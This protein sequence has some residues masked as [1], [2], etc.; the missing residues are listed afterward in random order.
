[1]RFVRIVAKPVKFH[2]SR[3][4]EDQF[5][6]KSAFQNINPEDDKMKRC[7]ICKSPHC[8]AYLSKRL[9]GTTLRRMMI[10]AKKEF[11]E[12][13]K[14]WEFVDHFE[15]HVPSQKK[16]LDSLKQEIKDRTKVNH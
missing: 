14:T 3:H 8:E 16:E 10:Y 2:L 7:R 1:M 15:N 5:I 13:I 12:K 6:A 11:G 9:E 4:P